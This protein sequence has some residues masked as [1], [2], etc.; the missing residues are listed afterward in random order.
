MRHLTFGA[1][2]GADGLAAEPPESVVLTPAVG[3]MLVSTDGVSTVE[4]RSTTVAYVSSSEPIEVTVTGA[5]SLTIAEGLP[6]D[7][8]LTKAQLQQVASDLGLSTSGLKAEILER[9]Q[10]HLGA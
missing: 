2:F 9:I 10:A 7:A 8:S 6:V 3:V 5:T 1:E 4:G